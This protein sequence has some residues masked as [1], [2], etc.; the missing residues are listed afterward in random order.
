MKIVILDAYA[1]NPGDV[2]WDGLKELGDATI[3]DH[4][5]RELSLE[6]IRD[7]EI[8]LVNKTEFTGE[9]MDK[10]EKL[11]YIGELATGYNNIDL[12]AATE[13]R[14]PV[15]NIPAYSTPSVVQHTFAL[16]LELCMH[17]GQHSEGVMAGKWNKCRDFC[18]WEMPLMEL[19]GKTLGIIG[20]GQIGREVAKTAVCFG[21]KVIACAAHPKIE[22]GIEGVTMTTMDE[23]IATS[24]I[25]S[26]HCPLTQESKGLICK[27]TIAKM[28]NGVIII[29]TARGGLINEQDAAEALVSGKLGGFAADVLAQEPPKDGNPLFGCP[30][31]I[32]TPHIGW[33]P[34]ESRKRLID[35]ATENVRAFLDGHP[36]NKVNQ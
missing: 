11:K 3:Y 6:R 26:L 30:N 14:I 8:V 31:C 28:R 33:A 10:C 25:I 21:M 19:S 35:V 34:I 5:P 16:L 20:F 15:C 27:E 4:T 23:I 22:S 18:Y 29:N 2:S 7:A 9:L 1:I 24:D 32:I 12:K 13:H 17:T 36:Q